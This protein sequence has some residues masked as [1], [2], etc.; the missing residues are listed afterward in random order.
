MQT[1][2]SDLVLSTSRLPFSRGFLHGA[3]CTVFPAA[4]VPYDSPFTGGGL[5]LKS[6]HSSVSCKF[7]PAGRGPER[8][9]LSLCS[10]S[11]LEL[12]RFP[13]RKTLRP[14]S[15]PASTGLSRPARPAAAPAGPA[16]RLAARRLPPGSGRLPQDSGRGR[17][18]G[19][20]PRSGRPRI[21]AAARASCEGNPSI[22]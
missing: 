17:V 11:S 22:R 9:A 15:S 13:R 21:P 3:L 19:L 6:V 2:R 7:P 1:V 16:A 20:A 10:R 12:L 8:V 4:L 5:P 14:L 18:A